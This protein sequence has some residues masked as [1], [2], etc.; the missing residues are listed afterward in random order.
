MSLRSLATATLLL[1]L[2]A[3]GTAHA[4]GGASGP[5]GRR[6][7]LSVGAPN[8]GR[9]QG[10]VELRPSHAI[11]LSNPSGA[12]WGL[13]QL[14]AL[15]VRSA[16]RLSARFT[17]RALL[18]G[19]LSLRAGGRIAGHRSHESGRDADVAFVFSGPSG[20]AVTTDGFVAVDENGQVVDRPGYHFDVAANWALV[21]AWVTDPGA[22][23]ERIFVA[24]HLRA[25]LLAYA[26]SRGTYLPVLQRAALA[27]EQPTRGQRHD[28]HFHVRIR[29]PKEQRDVCT[30]ARNPSSVAPRVTIASA[31]ARRRGGPTRALVKPRKEGETTRR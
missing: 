19:D 2:T 4:A 21:E 13:P 26:R 31:H 11:R 8:R 12:H 6:A 27:L 23:V 1:L 22:R 16:K 7:A 25:R 28:D 29:C 14:V 5:R 18:V 9:L 3:P 10:A 24:E 30:Q 15:L 17:G 20:E